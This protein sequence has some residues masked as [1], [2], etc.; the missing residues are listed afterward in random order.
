LEKIFPNPIG[1]DVHHK[2]LDNYGNNDRD[3]HPPGETDV[4]DDPYGFIVLDGDEDALQGAFQQNYIFTHV[5]DG[6]NIPIQ[7]RETLTRDDP[8]VLDWVFEHEETF[9][10]IYCRPGKEDE[11][12]KIFLGGAA[13]TIISLPRH[14]GSGPYARVVSME[15]VDTAHLSA[16]HRRKRSVQ[17]HNSTVYNLTIDYRF[18]LIKREDSRVNIRIDYTNLVPYWDDLTGK[19]S[20]AGTTNSKRAVPRHEKRWWGGYTDWLRKLT[21]VRASD[22]GKLP[23]SIH[24]NMLLYSKRASCDR[25]NVKMEAALDVTLDA[26]FDMNAR[27]AYYAQGSIVPLNID[28]IYAYFELEPV[29]SAVLEVQ[30]TAEIQYTSD[31]LKIIDTLSYPGLAIKGIA[32][33]GP[34]LDMYGQMEAFARIA[35]TLT[36]GAKV[37]FPRYEMYFPQAPEAEEYQ[38]WSEPRASDEER[39][40]GPQMEPILAASV[41]AYAHFDFHLTPE[42]NLGIRV[43][44]PVGSGGPLMDAQIIGYVNNT[45]RFQVEGHAKGSLDTPPSAS[46]DIYIKYLYNF[47][48]F[49]AC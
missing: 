17:S 2:Y 33:I 8:N 6:T 29:A 47:G 21:T 15:A 41:N 12:S 49:P 14:I 27:W 36:A 22:Q 16:F 23:M 10:L 44:S 13:D 4:G 46:Y 18:E 3:P 37:T 28:A 25:N 34:T 30:G 19:E 42:A 26:Y 5:N 31:R 20:D 43:N 40:T 32:A 38:V 1:E 48:E 35:G 7:K 9:H 11:C 45:L 39:I 24:K